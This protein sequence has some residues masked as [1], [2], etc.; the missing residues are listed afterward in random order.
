VVKV[1]KVLQ[2]V[3]AAAIPV[4]AAAGGSATAAGAL[5]AGVVV[6]EGLQQLFQ[7]QQNWT[8]YRATCEALKHEKF[9]FLARADPYGSANQEQLLA[10]RVEALVSEETSTWAAQRAQQ[11]APGTDVSGG[12]TNA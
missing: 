8:S 10:T 7:F 11:A 2:I 9:L 3:I 5:G 4:I 6:L 1:L 12:A